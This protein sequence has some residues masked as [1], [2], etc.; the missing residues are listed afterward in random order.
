ME[1][2]LGDRAKDKISG[3]KGIVIARTVWLNGCVRITIQPEACN[4]DGSVIENQTFDVH[5]M[6]LVKSDA[7]EAA[8]ESRTGGPS[9]KPTR[10]R[11]PR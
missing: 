1:I 11:D 4:K 8:R 7:L 6:E 5:Q 3:F 9:I 10:S 2:K